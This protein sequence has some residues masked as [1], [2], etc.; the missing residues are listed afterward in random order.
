[1]NEFNA[2]VDAIDTRCSPV[3]HGINT[4][5]L[6]IESFHFQFLVTKLTAQNGHNAA[7][8][9]GCKNTRPTH[10]KRGQAELPVEKVGSI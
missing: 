1:M 9:I 6:R 4:H 10:T 2:E 5:T 3:F 7:Q 8:N